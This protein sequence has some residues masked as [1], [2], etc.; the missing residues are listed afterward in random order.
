LLA[1][2]GVSFGRERSCDVAAEG[3]D[4]S[5]GRERCRVENEQER[6]GNGWGRVGVA[7]EREPGPAGHQAGGARDEPLGATAGRGVS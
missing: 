5:G 4:P 3:D 2:H 6:R 1:V 7:V